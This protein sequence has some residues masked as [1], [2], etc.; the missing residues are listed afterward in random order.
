VTA[1]LFLAFGPYC[2]GTVPCLHT[3]L[4]ALL[5]VM[6]VEVGYLLAVRQARLRFGAAVTRQHIT[7]FTA[8]VLVIFLGAGTPIHD[9]SEQYLF[10]VHMFQHT[11]FTLVAPP[12]LLL[13]LAEPL[14]KPLVKNPVTFRV[15][16]SL[17]YPLIAFV[18]FN[19]I[20]LVTHLPFA[21]DFSLR[22]H[23]FHFVIH[24]ILVLSALLMWWPILSP[25]KEIPRL[26]PPFQ[27]GF[28][29]I[30]SLVPTVLTAFII[31][32]GHSIYEFYRDVPRIWGTTAISDQQLAGAVMKLVGGF[33]LWIAIGIIFF[34]WFGQEEAKEHQPLR[35]EDVESELTEMG[36]TRRP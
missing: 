12:L 30:Q 15:I 28:L 35:W 31:F 33:I 9:I 4:D 25:V 14:L 3:H 24:V 8:G 34:R 26:S 29:F 32:A 17:T 19:L 27:M 10:S 11:I 36:L 22:N 1:V 5:L 13:G 6:L 23:P 2:G 16:K 18:I 7:Y 21:V 20:T